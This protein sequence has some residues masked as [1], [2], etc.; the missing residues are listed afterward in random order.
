MGIRTLRILAEISGWDL[1]F[2]ISL[3]DISLLVRNFYDNIKMS[4]WKTLTTRY[5][6]PMPIKRVRVRSLAR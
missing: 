2:F 4:W 1:W 3:T 5:R 6:D